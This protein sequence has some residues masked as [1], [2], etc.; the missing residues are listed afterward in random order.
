MYQ[1]DQRQ[2]SHLY[3]YVCMYVC[4]YVRTWI[5]LCHILKNDLTIFTLPAWLICF[6]CLCV[7]VSECVD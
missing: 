4:M 3:M 5:V 6:V 2:H 7:C 1:T